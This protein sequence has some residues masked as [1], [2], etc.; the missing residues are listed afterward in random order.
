MSRLQFVDS[1]FSFFPDSDDGK[2]ETECNDTNCEDDDA[3]LGD[4]EDED[5][6]EEGALSDS[7]ESRPVSEKK[8]DDDEELPHKTPSIYTAGPAKPESPRYLMPD[9]APPVIDP[10]IPEPL[11][12]TSML[13][14]FVEE[15]LKST[16]MSLSLL[17]RE[18]AL[19]LDKVKP[20][21]ATPCLEARRH[22]DRHKDR[23]ERPRDKNNHK[24]SKSGVIRKTPS[25]QNEHLREIEKLISM[26][27][28][29]DSHRISP[30]SRMYPTSPKSSTSHK[31]PSKPDY[32]QHEEPRPKSPDSLYLDP[33]ETDQPL[34]LSKKPKEMLDS[35]SRS[36]ISITTPVPRSE[37]NSLANLEKKFGGNAFLFDGLGS[38]YSSHRNTMYGAFG[39][40]LFTSALY[41]TPPLS[42]PSDTVYRPNRSFWPNVM[43]TAAQAVCKSFPSTPVKPKP[44]VANTE[45]KPK[46]EAEVRV[47]RESREELTASSGRYTNLTCSCR[48]AFETLFELTIHMQKT[49]H[50]PTPM[51]TCDQ[52]EYPKLVRGQDMWLNQGSEQTRQI[53]R[54]MQCGES[55]KSLPELTIHMMNTKHYTNIVGSDTGRKQHKCSTYCEKCPNEHDSALKCKY[56]LGSFDDM[57]SLSKHM[58]SCHYKRQSPSVEGETQYLQ[59][60]RYYSNKETPPPKVIKPIENDSNDA[61][62]QSNNTNNDNSDSE[63]D[64]MFECSKIRCENCLEKIDTPNF[65]EHVRVCV[66]TKPRVLD[67]DRDGSRANADVPVPASYSAKTKSERKGEEEGHSSTPSPPTLSPP[68]RYPTPGEARYSKSNGSQYSDSHPPSMDKEAPSPKRENFS[69]RNG[70]S[71]PLKGDECSQE[72]LRETRRSSSRD[73]P[74]PRSRRPSHA[75]ESYLDF[76][77]RSSEDTP[78]DH[79]GRSRSKDNGTSPFTP[80]LHS[81]TPDLEPASSEGSALKAMENFIER[82]FTSSMSKMGSF[83]SRP[84]LN[85][86]MSLR[87]PGQTSH[88]H[89]YLPSEPMALT[90]PQRPPSQQ[91][92]L[93]PS[94]P[95]QPLPPV[96]KKEAPESPK[97]K[98]P[99]EPI[100]IKKEKKSPPSSPEPGPDPTNSVSPSKRENG[101]PPSPALPKEQYL[102]DT[103]QPPAAKSSALESLQGL[104]YGKSFS[105]EHPLDSLQK[106]IHNTDGVT[107]ANNNTNGTMSHMI[108]GP[109]NLS[110]GLPNTVILVNPIVTVVPSNSAPPAVQISLP[111]TDGPVTTPSPPL[112]G[113]GHGASKSPLSEGEADQLGD[114]RCQACNRSFASKGSYRYH[115]SRCHLSSVKRYGIKEAFNMSP[116][117]YL[118][119]DHTAKFN[120]YYEMA[121]ELANKGK[122]KEAEAAAEVV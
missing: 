75:E 49:G 72:A 94:P 43:G 78:A 16:S 11:G 51:K 24:S 27:K 122:L 92:Y 67:E 14:S 102:Q 60:E 3:E 95:S 63:S 91:R 56:C 100:P 37:T 118:P 41:N 39:G 19:E 80:A 116:Y 25:I 111:G 66:K 64:D 119:L 76:S 58:I 89:R 108:T 50:L 62:R 53:L 13:S 84:S 21:P 55:F 42:S 22:L 81:T 12:T 36:S 30:K 7:E 88:M 101:K 59:Q 52:S 82:S 85:G 109:T 40:N 26:S 71:S 106:L 86:R 104:V 107:T 1:L 74:Q 79:R 83:G 112:N 77:R 17:P 9:T 57:D 93:N 120:K 10:V 115:L 29:K 117:V 69:P 96:I 105:T 2:E 54:C 45:P 32:I 48:K 33:F 99:C 4:D 114:Y 98:D 47:Q 90:P 5:D 44:P 35:D 18:S 65:V 121:N 34:D 23:L 113:F 15:R 6:T 68:Q 73:T 97:A 28:P 38:K 61:S 70:I 20:A 87:M 8:D 46:P 31:T 110:T 103:A